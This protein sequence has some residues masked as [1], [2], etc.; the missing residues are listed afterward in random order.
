MPSGLAALEAMGLSDLLAVIPTRPLTDWCFQV[1]SQP[2]FQVREPWGDPRPCTLVPQ[3]NLLAAV[4][5]RCRRLSTVTVELGLPVT[6]LVI[7]ADSSIEGIGLADGDRRL[8]R[9]VVAA[10]GR[11]SILRRLAGLEL[12][13]GP[14]PEM[15]VDWFHLKDS[16]PISTAPAAPEDRGTTFLS[17]I[18]GGDLFSCF[19]AARGDGRHLALVREPRDPPPPCGDRLAE[20]LAT[21]APQP[22]AAWLRRQGEA[23]HQPVSLQVR[24]GQA[25]CWHRP[26]LLLIGD[27]AHP[28]SPVRAQGLNMALRDALIAARLLEPALTRSPLSAAQQQDRRPEDVVQ[29]EA[30]CRLNRALAAIEARRRPEISSMQRLQAQESRR[31]LLLRRQPLL[32]AVLAK[33]SPWLG[34][35][36]RHHWM[37]SQ[38]PLRL[39]LDDLSDDA[40]M[41]RASMLR[42]IAAPPALVVALLLGSGLQ[43]GL[44][45]PLQGPPSTESLRRIQLEAQICGRDNTEVSCA[46]ARGLA[47]ALLDHDTVSASCKDSAFE[48]VQR[49]RVSDRMTDGRRDR[50]DGVAADLVR[51]CRPRARAVGDAGGG[52][53]KPG[54][55][56]SSPFSLRGGPQNG[57]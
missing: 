12:D 51:F 15:I 50:I 23:L 48:L 24:V 49:A 34:P 54:D 7:A 57:L 32:R 21:I 45:K 8:A 22:L 9:L 17:V 10:D 2:L 4:L 44:S 11:E 31:G 33:A 39:G 41:P 38:L 36:L 1:D 56:G 47:D 27:A 55:G 30:R 3:D 19:D 43:A 52:T 37:T 26:G 46:R 6:S 13:A 20:R 42:S 5:D 40:R 29:P 16:G 35:R 25:R 14:G 28:M 18:A 53:G